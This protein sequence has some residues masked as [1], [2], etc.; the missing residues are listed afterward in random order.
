[1]GGSPMINLGI[2]LADG[3]R[4]LNDSKRALE[5]AQCLEAHARE[6]V[7]TYRAD[8]V[9]PISGGSSEP[10]W[11]PRDHLRARLRFLV[12]AHDVPS[13]FA[14]Y[15]TDNGAC[16]ICGKVIVRGALEYEIA[17][18]TLTFV[19]DRRCFALWQGQMHVLQR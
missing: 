16:D 19:L 3:A 13:I 9:R 2:L 15:A 6:L 17:F 5:H 1:M 11:P 8:R 14:G 12:N 18:S 4:V 7:L 10:P